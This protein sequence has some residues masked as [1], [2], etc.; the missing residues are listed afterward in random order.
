MPIDACLDDY[1]SFR[2]SWLSF[3][4]QVPKMC[5]LLCKHATFLVSAL[6]LC[7][8]VE[9]CISRIFRVGFLSFATMDYAKTGKLGLVKKFPALEVATSFLRVYKLNLQ[10]SR[11]CL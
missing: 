8:L 11:R 7:L 10:R 9:S 6:Q 2:N 3:V 5:F 1:I 4:W